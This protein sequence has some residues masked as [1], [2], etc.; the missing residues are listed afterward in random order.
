MCFEKAP[1]R[2]LEG[3][4]PGSFRERRKWLFFRQKMRRRR[5]RFAFFETP[6]QLHENVLAFYHNPK[7]DVQMPE[8]LS[9]G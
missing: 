5:D 2:T 1:V 9:G 8:K 3:E 6:H 7:I 4:D